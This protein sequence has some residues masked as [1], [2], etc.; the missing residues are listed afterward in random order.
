MGMGYG[1]FCLKV[2]EDAET[3]IYQYGAFNWN[4]PEFANHEGEKDGLITFSKDI[5]VEPEIRLKRRKKP[6][7]GHR[8]FEKKII[9][10]VGIPIITGLRTGEIQ[11]ENSRFEWEI[12]EESRNPVGK[13]ALWVL[14]EIF[15]QYQEDGQL[16]ENAGFTS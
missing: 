15:I 4:L 16:P 13:T 9:R 11:I 14:M 5:L 7:G 8:F 6:G 1:C 3:A 2:A 12:F 10:E